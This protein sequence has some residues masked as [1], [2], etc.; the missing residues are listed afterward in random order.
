MRR[1]LLLWNHLSDVILCL[2]LLLKDYMLVWHWLQVGFQVSEIVLLGL[3]KGGCFLGL[4]LQ[5]MLGVHQVAL[6]LVQAIV[7][8]IAHLHFG[9]RGHLT[10][11]VSITKVVFGEQR[12][13]GT[14]TILSPVIARNELDL[15]C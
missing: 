14:C 1:T 4:L 13:V 2:F 6:Q 12:E 8:H 11:V 9:E 5:L 7:M 10:H 3:D 15:R